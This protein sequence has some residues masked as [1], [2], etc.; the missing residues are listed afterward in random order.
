[1]ASPR[2]AA[3]SSVLAFAAL[4]APAAALT[5]PGTASYDVIIDF[6]PLAESDRGDETFTL[7]L[8]P[9]DRRRI[10]RNARFASQA[11][12]PAFDASRGVPLG[13]SIAL[14]AQVAPT[15]TGPELDPLEFLIYNFRDFIVTAGLEVRSSSVLQPIFPNPTASMEID[16]A[17]VRDGVVLSLPGDLLL[18]IDDV[19]T[20]SPGQLAL[21]AGG[22]E[23]LLFDFDL[24]LD[25]EYNS[26]FLGDLEFEFFPNASA[27]ATL[28]YEYQPFADPEHPA[29]IP[30]P[31]AW[32]LS[33][34]GVAALTAARRRRRSGV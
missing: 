29:A 10:G 25:L 3:L 18:E 1:M 5:V 11:R 32:L 14:D 2:T 8:S 24:T 9:S 17:D 12:L 4:A 19:Y 7:A 31:G 13:A 20:Y 34:S 6:P 33:L 22:S 27:T 23:R 26:S 30:L 15:A 28:T 21:V 16:A